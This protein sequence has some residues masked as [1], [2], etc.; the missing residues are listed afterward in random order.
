M[1]TWLTWAIVSLILL[2]GCGSKN[3]ADPAAVAQAVSATLAAISTPI[4]VTVEVTRV[5]EVEVAPASTPI[6]QA[7][8]IP[9]LAQVIPPR[10]YYIHS[11]EVKEEYDR[12]TDKTKVSI[13]PKY[14]EIGIVEQG[15]LSVLYSY[16]GKT[17]SPPLAVGIGLW[18]INDKWEYLQCHTLDLLIDGSPLSVKTEHKGEVMSGSVLETIIGELGTRDFLSIVNARQ[19]EGKLCNTVFKLSVDQMQALKDVASRMSTSTGVALEE[20]IPPPAYDVALIRVDAQTTETGYTITGTFDNLGNNSTPVL[21]VTVTFQE[22]NTR[23]IV[24]RQAIIGPLSSGASGNFTIINITDGNW[25]YTIDLFTSD[26][27]SLPY[28]DRTD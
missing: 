21:T 26:G 2:T 8:S 3:Q 25:D 12:F 24:K 19:V 6:P 15:A 5:V 10:G 20:T 4:P 17:P 13:E 7:T 28:R 14:D 11:Y 27:E 9:A 18:S 22:R 1:K 16:D 23:A